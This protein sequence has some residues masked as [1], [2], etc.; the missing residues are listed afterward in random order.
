MKNLKNLLNKRMVRLR[1][2]G[3]VAYRPDWT[4]GFFEQ[5]QD[6]LHNKGSFATVKLYNLHPFTTLD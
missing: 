2:I 6:L 4:S 3:I 5:Q 1:V